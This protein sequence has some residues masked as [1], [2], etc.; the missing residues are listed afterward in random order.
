M[1][2]AQDLKRKELTNEG[3]YTKHIRF[4]RVVKVYDSDTVLAENKN[5]GL[6]DLA[7]VDTN[8]KVNGSVDF[9]KSGYSSNFGYG[10]IVMP[11][12]GDIAACYTLSASTPIILGFISRNQWRA[13]IADKDNADDIAHMPALKSGEIL[14]KGS[15]QSTIHVKKDGLIKIVAKDGTNTTPVPNKNA[16]FGSDKFFDKVSDE[17]T[18]TVLEMELGNSDKAAGPAKQI[19]SL[20]SGKSSTQKYV[21]NAA[22][23]VLQYSLT[24]A[25]QVEIEGIESIKLYSVG[26]DGKRVL[27]KTLGP[28]SKVRL[29]KTYYYTQALLDQ[30]DTSKNTCTLDSNGIITSFTLP[31]NVAGLLAKNTELE[32]TVFVKK[33][34]FSFKV[35]GLGDVLIDCRNFVVRTKENKSCLGL[36]ENSHT[37]LSSI[38]NEIGN[39]LTGYIRTDRGGVHTSAGTF[40]Y[41]KLENVEAADS[42]NITGE[43]FYFYILD[44]FPLIAYT[45]DNKAQ[46]YHFVSTA[47]YVGLSAK[48][49]TSIKC[50]PFDSDFSQEGFN[51]ER[52]TN[53]LTEAEKNNQKWMPYGSLRML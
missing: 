53:L 23:N 47:E 44:E 20:T 31:A 16:Q 37:V 34:D 50:K 1:K 5:Y 11:S 48:E 25:T 40:Q 27:K 15:S 4:A 22:P 51:R 45:P 21:L 38:T 14:I 35:N 49:R 3:D 26:T 8:D 9:L 52:F 33:P 43:T 24:P 42:K 13:L 17:D 41:A 2:S 36:F 46:P 6:V 30:N 32:V 18:N 19:F 12:V 7:W 10:V 29:V 28:N 39:K